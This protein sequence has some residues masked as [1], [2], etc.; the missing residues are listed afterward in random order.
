MMND[1]R[2]QTETPHGVALAG[3]PVGAAPSSIGN[4]AMRTKLGSA[5]F[6]RLAGKFLRI[7]RV[8]SSKD[9]I[10]VAKWMHSAGRL[11]YQHVR[12]KELLFRRVPLWLR[13]RPHFRFVRDMGQREPEVVPQDFW[14][15]YWWYGVLWLHQTRPDS[16]I[17]LPNHRIARVLPPKHWE[18]FDVII[19]FWRARNASHAQLFQTWNE[20]ARAS[21]DA[22]L[23]LSAIL[24]ESE[25][26]TAGKAQP[27]PVKTNSQSAIDDSVPNRLPKSAPAELKP[28][29]QRAWSQGDEAIKN[30]PEL[31][32]SSLDE[33]YT[34]VAE[35]ARKEGDKVAKLNTWK[36]YLRAA[37]AYKTRVCGTNVERSADFPHH[38]SSEK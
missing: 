36:R 3:P 18:I 23:Y 32:K 5:G 21:R 8:R 37:R 4:A 27:P 13:T 34:A 30:D 25:P 20:I 33:L 2:I 28:W 31:A 24:A 22:C 29:E 10:E 11:L 15:T 38:N 1:P 14:D 12:R 26:S 35:R 7:K 17:E 16:C 19:Q 9:E 6:R